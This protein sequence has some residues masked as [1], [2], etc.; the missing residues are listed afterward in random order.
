MRGI[1]AGI[2]CAPQARLACGWP[3]LGKRTHKKAELL[4][5]GEAEMRLVAP[6]REEDFEAKRRCLGILFSEEL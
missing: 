6:A 1:R 3:A 4:G 5:D 2:F